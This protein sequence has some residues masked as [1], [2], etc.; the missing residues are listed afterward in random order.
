[1]PNPSMRRPLTPSQR[2]VL[3]ALITLADGA[4]TVAAGTAKLVTLT[5]LTPKQVDQG[6]NGLVDM[7]ALTKSWDPDK[8][9]WAYTFAD[10]PAN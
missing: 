7:N 3:A 5:G 9:V 4:P 2:D 6:L 10:V 1:M 8:Y